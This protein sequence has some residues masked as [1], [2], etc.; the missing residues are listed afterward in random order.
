[1]KI[2]YLPRALR[3]LEDAPSDVRRAFLSGLSCRQPP[4]SVAARQ[5]VRRIQRPLAGPC[6]QGMAVLF[7]HRRR[8]LYHPR[9]RATSEEVNRLSRNSQKYGETRRQGGRFNGQERGAWYA[10]RESK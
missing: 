6:Q 10:A 1:M 7:Q 9:Y 5:E 8:Y 3:S 4:P 2:D